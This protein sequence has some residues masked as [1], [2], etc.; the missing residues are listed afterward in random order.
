MIEESIQGIQSD[1]DRT[2]YEH[3]KILL[4]MSEKN[5]ELLYPYWDVFI[6]LLR[7]DKVS[8]K[9]AAIRLISNLVRVDTEHKFEELFDEFFQHLSHESPVVSPHVAG[10]S[11]KIVRARPH[12]KRR[13][14][15]L[16][17]DVDE[18]SRCRHLGLLKSYVIEA[19]DDYFEE[20]GEKGRI[21][22]FVRDQLNSDS[23]K[24]KKT[25]RWFLKKW[26]EE[27]VGLDI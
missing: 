20:S 16:L 19:F 17:L 11:G 25:A 14:T 10:N 21:V 1:N 6:E 22:R 2:R 7:R 3:F 9:H 15:E 18:T 26:E 5:P 12:L 4:S 24:T 23:P 8:C 27:I 13:I